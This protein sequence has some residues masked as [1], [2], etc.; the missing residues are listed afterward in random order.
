MRAPVRQRPRL[1]SLVSRSFFFLSIYSAFQLECF[2]YFV[3]RSDRKQQQHNFSLHVCFYFIYNNGLFFLFIHHLY[4]SR[5][6]DWDDIDW[7]SQ[8]FIYLSHAIDV[9]YVIYL[10]FRNRMSTWLKT[11]S[12]Q[13]VQRHNTLSIELTGVLQVM[14]GENGRLTRSVTVV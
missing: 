5:H 1:S 4:C 3:K 10:S 8:L 7:S 11:S 6:Q 14:G 13:A 2:I 9:Q 12:S